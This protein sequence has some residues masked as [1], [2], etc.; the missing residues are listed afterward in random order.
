M[1]TNIKH[2]LAAVI[3]TAAGITASTQVGVHVGASRPY[4][5][6]EVSLSDGDVFQDTSICAPDFPQNFN[7]YSYCL[8]NPL[9]YVDENREVWWI[10]PVALAAIFAIGCIWEFSPLIPFI[11]PA[12]QAGMTYSG[13]SQVAIGLTGINMGRNLRRKTRCVKCNKDFLGQ[14]Q[15]WWKQFLW[16]CVARNF[17]AYLKSAQTLIGAGWSYARNIIGNVD[18]VD[19]IGGATFITNENSKTIWGW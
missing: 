18:R 12:A 2:I 1:N 16:R 4:Q 10:V 3:L 11:G 9:S 15:S 6:T 19:Y 8:N 17:E 5:I 14:F 7:R 13:M